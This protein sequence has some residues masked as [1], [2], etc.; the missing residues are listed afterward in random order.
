VSTEVVVTMSQS[1]IAVPANLVAAAA[2][3]VAW[4]MLRRITANQLFQANIAQVF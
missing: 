1:A 4:R 2:S 3:L